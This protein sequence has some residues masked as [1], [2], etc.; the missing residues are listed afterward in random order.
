MNMN[1]YRKNMTVIKRNYQTSEGEKLQ[2][3]GELTKSL[4]DPSL[5]Y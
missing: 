3:K 2:S 4:S 1:Y 5:S